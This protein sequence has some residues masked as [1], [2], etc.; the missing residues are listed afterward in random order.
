[1]NRRGFLGSMLALAAAPAIVRADSLM[2]IVSLE[3]TVLAAPLAEPG[4]TEAALKEM[5]RKVWEAGGE[6]DI[7]RVGAQAAQTIETWFAG[8]A[9]RFAHG[10]D[11]RVIEPVSLYVS[12]FGCSRVVVDRNM[13]LD[14]WVVE[15]P[16]GFAGVLTH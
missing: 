8:A 6:P 1:V 13:G 11:G 15:S 5:I 3:T 9:T 14:A 4:L 10:W 2:R 12:D 7:I 16:G